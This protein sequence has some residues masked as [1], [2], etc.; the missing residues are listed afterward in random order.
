MAIT[1][2]NAKDIML[3]LLIASIIITQGVL[4]YGL[5]QIDVEKITDSDAKQ[6]LK[7]AKKSNTGLIVMLVINLII[8]SS[9]HWSKSL[10]CTKPNRDKLY[11]TVYI[12]MFIMLVLNLVTLFSL[13][14]VQPARLTSSE[15]SSFKTAKG[16]A[17]ASFAFTILFLVHQVYKNC[18]EWN[19]D[20]LYDISKGTKDA[21]GRCFGYQD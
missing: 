8:L 9:G 12:G 13:V 5:S 17:I 21:P 18:D 2:E 6:A 14:A 7:D 20:S 11:I 19:F 4:W 1:T 10:T 3:Y 16:S 15:Q